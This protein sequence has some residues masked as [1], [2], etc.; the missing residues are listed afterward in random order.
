V[1]DDQVNPVIKELT[2]PKNL[3]AVFADLKRT[4]FPVWD[5]ANRW[6][7]RVSSG[8]PDIFASAECNYARKTIY[9]VPE[10]FQSVDKLR[11]T[12]VH[13]ICHAIYPDRGHMSKLFQRILLRVAEQAQHLDQQTLA[14]DLRRQARGCQSKPLTRISFRRVL[15]DVEELLNL[16][17]SA[18]LY[19]IIGT[20]AE[21]WAREPDEL[22]KQYPTLKTTIRKMKHDIANQQRS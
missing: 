1:D 6:R 17:P 18:P 5:K 20:I 12:L 3:A 9:I 19:V 2:K 14:D 16:D 21:D 22:L 7:V 8:L 11:G 13:E 15:L 4:Y 10:G